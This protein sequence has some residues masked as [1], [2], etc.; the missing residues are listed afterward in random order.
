[1]RTQGR[2]GLGCGGQG[3]GGLG[4]TPDPGGL[5]E[6]ARPADFCLCPF[7]GL[8][9]R[10]LHL[11]PRRL[12]PCLWSASHLHGD[13]LI[14]VLREGGSPPPHCFGGAPCAVPWSG[15]RGRGS[16]GDSWLGD[17]GAPAGVSSRSLPWA[18]KV[19]GR[20]EA[21][22]SFLPPSLRLENAPLLLLPAEGTS[23]LTLSP[24]GVCVFFPSRG[25][26]WGRASRGYGF[27][28]GRGYT[29]GKGLSSVFCSSASL[30]G[31]IIPPTWSPPKPS[32]ACPLPDPLGQFSL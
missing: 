13:F 4:L 9:F 29:L 27:L 15:G 17:G 20:H 14:L 24:E 18:R 7:F 1:M 28:L 2:A 26:L 8:H 23:L 19:G 12:P 16:S 6:E 21:S 11:S 31:D 32:C 22:P 10:H 25:F 5:W 30:F 3:S